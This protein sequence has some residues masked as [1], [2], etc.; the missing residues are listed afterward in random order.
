MVAIQAIARTLT[1]LANHSDGGPRDPRGLGGYGQLMGPPTADTCLFAVVF[2]GQYLPMRS[3]GLSTK[4]MR[5]RSIT[6]PH[7]L[8]RFKSPLLYQLSYRVEYAKRHQG[9]RL[10]QAHRSPRGNA[11]TGL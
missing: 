3:N 11:S 8:C 2:A 6:L 4:P 10:R 5:E 1:A 9:Q 7:R